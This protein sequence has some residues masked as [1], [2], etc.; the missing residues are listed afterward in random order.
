MIWKSFEMNI[1]S[2]KLKQNPFGIPL[3]IV[4]AMSSNVR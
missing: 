2:E 3:N 1:L 4:S